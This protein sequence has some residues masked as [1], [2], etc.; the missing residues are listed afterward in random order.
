MLQHNPIWPPLPKVVYVHMDLR[1][2]FSREANHMNTCLSVRLR[3]KT[4]CPLFIPSFKE[5]AHEEEK[6]TI[7]LV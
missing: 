3:E 2:V 6:E 4:K 1:F 5:Q 7:I